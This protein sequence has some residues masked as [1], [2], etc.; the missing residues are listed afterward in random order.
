MVISGGS[1]YRALE[2]AVVVRG[3]SQAWLSAGTVARVGGSGCY[4]V[5]PGEHGAALATVVTTS[6]EVNDSVIGYG[7]LDP[8]AVNARLLEPNTVPRAALLGPDTT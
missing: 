4:R 1:G 6:A 7:S 2:A 5:D 8:R 3:L